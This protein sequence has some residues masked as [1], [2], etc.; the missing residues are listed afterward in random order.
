VS[1]TFDEVHTSLASRDWSGAEADR[2][3]GA[4]VVHSTR[5]SRQLTG[6]L[7]VE[8]ERRGIT[9][10]EL[11][12]EYVAAGLDAAAD[13]ETTTVT[14]RLADLHRAIDTAVRRAAYAPTGGLP[15]SGP[16]PVA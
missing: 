1:E 10:S 9:P 7:F 2:P 14:V 16:H 5:M 6:R 4:T 13:V 12:R 11:I 15:D 3:R 8:A